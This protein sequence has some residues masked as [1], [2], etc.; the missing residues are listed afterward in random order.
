LNEAR[1]ATRAVP[2]LLHFTTIGIE[3]TVTE[4]CVWQRR[5]LDQQQLI[6]TDAK[7][8]IGDKTHLLTRQRNILVDRIDHNE[9]VTETVHFGEFELHDWD[10]TAKAQR[11]QRVSGFY[12]KGAKEG[13]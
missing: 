10:F 13:W 1:E 7:V 8:A 5:P 9:I 3:Y 4:L 6:A 11:T 12:R 2:A